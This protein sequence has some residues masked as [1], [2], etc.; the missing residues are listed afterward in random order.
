MI[1][2]ESD[3]VLKVSENVDPRVWDEGF[4]QS[5][6][7][8]LFKSRDYEKE[9][10]EVALRFL[11]SG[12]YKNIEDLARENFANNPI[13]RERFNNNFESMRND[14]DLI[15]KLSATLDLATGTGKSY[16][17]IALALIML[18]SKKVTRVLVL[19]PSLTIESELTQKFV[20]IISNEQIIASLGSNFIAPSILNGDSTIIENSIAIENR[21]AIY[22]AQETRNS[23]IDSF[24]N[25]GENTLVLNDEV[26]HVYYTESNQWKNFI[27]DERNNNIIFKYI[28]GVTGTPYKRKNKTSTPNE[29]FSDVIY[30]YPLRN[31]IEQNF[32]KD[33]EYISK[34]DMPTDK[35]ERWQII[36]NSHDQIAK[37]LKTTFK[38]KPITIIV[39]ATQK[40]ADAQA[41]LFKKFLKQKRKL[42]DAQID[43]IVL[44]VH[45]GSSAKVDRL[46]LKH[47]DD[48]N[49]P[50]EF[51]FSVSMLTE[52]WDVKR[53]FQIVPDEERAFNS[54]LLIAQVL[55]RGLRKPNTWQDSWGTPTVT[56]FNHEKWSGNVQSLVNEILEIKK[57]LTTKVNPDSEYNFELLN[58]KYTSEAT[59]V[60]TPKLG[61][62]NLWENG[63]S[64]PTDSEISKSRIT[65][66]DVRNQ[67]SRD[68]ETE[69]THETFSID[70]IAETLYF[71][72]S[73]LEDTNFI[74]EYQNL[75]PVNRIK[76]MILTSLK[77]SGNTVITKHLKNKF[78]S[79]MNVIF[80]EGSK[81]VSYDTQP[82]E[83]FNIKTSQLPKVT[84]DLLAFKK[85]KVLFYTDELKNSL[86]DDPS[87]SSFADLTDT[88]NGYKHEKVTNK[89]NF[90][91]PQFS[92][93]VSSSP[94]VLFLKKL[95]SPEI[96]VSIDSF[97]KST[98]TKF[99]YFD[100]SWKK[101]SHQ[102]NGQFNP[103]WFIKQGDTYIIVDTK[104]DLQIS[105]PDSENIGK[106]KAAN[107]HFQLINEHY[108]SIGS[109]VRYKFTFLTPKNYDVFFEKLVNMNIMNFKSELD[110]KLSD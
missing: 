27:N 25:N 103:D 54:K 62:Y 22:S 1:Y 92:I 60:E 42:T 84:N 7:D 63:V 76:K 72:F 24:K 51:I 28:I 8:I 90:K 43:E 46:K 58:I 19:V 97:I 4:Y 2:K 53:V 81:S 87:I 108:A 5:F 38:E 94:E 30:R 70:E 71:R 17:M 15:N 31:A 45:S 89:Y 95:I 64:L 47:V 36:L 69:Y 83:F 100:Y 3:L 6:L 56:V 29:Y 74:Q 10:T 34:E 57:T 77:N 68:I 11:N 23:I 79:S 26:H 78:L 82:S 13:I 107:R 55:G 18:A 33:I 50:V 104:D 44:S 91:T 32:I 37:R 88:L 39:T 109:S 40:R 86:D 98:D 14:L 66:D 49:N 52:G 61:S 67:N 41:K 93:T 65:L 20:D 105:D 85:N 59:T 101:G 35:N 75:W 21:N 12:E 102:K 16:V 96:A 106:S 99:Y 9:A 80:R 73:D 48:P 110:V